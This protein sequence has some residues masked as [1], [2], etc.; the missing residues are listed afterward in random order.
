MRKLLIVF[1]LL[2][3]TL[4]LTGCLPKKSPPGESLLPEP[5]SPS[6]KP[7]SET[8]NERPYVVL[9]PSDDGHWVTLQI[10]KIKR[11][12][13]GLEYELT[14]FA[15]FEGNRIERGVSTGGKP[16]ELNGASEYSKKILFGSASCT[17]GIC[18]YRYDENVNEGML[19]LKLISAAGIEKFETV[20]RIQKGK[21]A[22]EGLTTGDG[23]FS[24]TAGN[25]SANKLY[26][27]ASSIGVPANLL[28]GMVAKSL[29]YV[30]FPFPQAKGEVSFK[31]VEKEAKIMLLDN[32]KWQE[33]ETA[34]SEGILSA[35]TPKSGI[36]I[37]V[38]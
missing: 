29:P 15:D 10:E 24:F 30:I 26:L 38:K 3:S 2:F 13:T 34:S 1:S 9:L 19:V 28:E 37:L 17:T 6:P 5:T 8:I 18:K 21:E 35:Q 4:L 12:T 31:T 23:V 11:G 14:Y 25:L 20:F 7:I 36:F 32:Q 27:T 22:K 33:L 16:V